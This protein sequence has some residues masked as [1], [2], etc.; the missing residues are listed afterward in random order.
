MIDYQHYND[1]ISKSIDEAYEC[2]KHRNATG[3]DPTSAVLCLLE[4]MQ[5]VRNLID[6]M[7]EQDKNC[8]GK[9]DD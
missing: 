6:E 7:A 9:E 3:F 4:A 8:E 1:A 2:L 5:E